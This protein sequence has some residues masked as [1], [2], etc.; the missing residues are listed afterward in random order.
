MTRVR[1]PE[2]SVCAGPARLLLQS[3]PGLWIGKKV[4]SIRKI[5]LTNPVLRGVQDPIGKDGVGFSSEQH[6][7]PI[8][9]RAFLAFVIEDDGLT[10]VEYAV[11]GTLITLAVVAAFSTLAGSVNGT[12]TIIDGW[13]PG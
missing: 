7:V 11:A 10:T 8:M 1:A 2:S 4:L 6:W 9:S 13:L 5:V 3:A 12:L